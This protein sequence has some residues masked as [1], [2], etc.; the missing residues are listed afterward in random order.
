MQINGRTDLRDI[1]KS[2]YIELSN[3]SQRKKLMGFKQGGMC[4][5]LGLGEKGVRVLFVP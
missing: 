1:Q 4:A 3:D 5:K 2:F